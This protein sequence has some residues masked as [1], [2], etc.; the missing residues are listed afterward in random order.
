MGSV[1]SG[2]CSSWGGD[3]EVPLKKLPISEW[4]KTEVLTTA[5]IEMFIFLSMEQFHSA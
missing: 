1:V 2:R 3:G 4:F 5:C